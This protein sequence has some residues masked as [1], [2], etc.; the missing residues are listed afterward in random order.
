MGSEEVIY[1][2]DV[3][4]GPPGKDAP[5]VE[6]NFANLQGDPSDNEALGQYI[7]QRVETV[8]HLNLENGFRIMSWEDILI[9]KLRKLLKLSLMKIFKQQL[10]R[11]L[12]PNCKTAR[13]WNFR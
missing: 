10:K 6:L 5:P 2:L 8:V 13:K 12:K 4:A 9:V 1:T 3:V 7:V 11:P